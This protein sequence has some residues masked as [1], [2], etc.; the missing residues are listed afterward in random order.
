MHTIQHAFPAVN[1]FLYF[2]ILSLISL[3]LKPFLPLPALPS[4]YSLLQLKCVKVSLLRITVTIL[5]LA[6]PSPNPKPARSIP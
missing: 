3:V 4:R 2:P 1:I 6:P 5:S